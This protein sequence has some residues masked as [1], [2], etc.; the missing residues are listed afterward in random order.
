MTMPRIA[1][2]LAGAVGHRVRQLR[3][4]D[5]IALAAAAAAEA[6]NR[7]GGP[8]LPLNRRR[9]AEMSAEGFVCCVDRLRERLGVVARVDLEE[10]FRRTGDWYRSERWL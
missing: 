3:V 10:G 6:L 2:A 9:L 5:P 8:A 7:F 1:D 4:P